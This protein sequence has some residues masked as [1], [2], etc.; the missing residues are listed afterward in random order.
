MRIL[1]VQFLALALAFAAA[2]QGQRRAAPVVADRPQLSEISDSIEGIGTLAPN[3]RVEL[4]VNVADRVTAIYFE[5]GQRV[6]RGQTLLAQAQREQLAAIEGAEAT[7]REAERVVERMTTLVADGVVSGLEFDQAKRNLEVARSE[8]TSV[9]T[10]QRNR[11]LVAP[12]D[13]VLGFRQVSV[14][15]FLSP[16]DPVATLVDDSEMY[17]DVFVPDTALANI[18]PGLDVVA[19]TS[20]LPGEIFNGIL[21]SVDNQI[22]PSTRSLRVRAR[23]PN[24]DQKLR[25]GLFMNVTLMAA[26]RTALSVP[27]AAVEP[28]GSQSFVYIVDRSENEPVARRTEVTLGSRFDGRVEV[29]SGLEISD[30]V[31]VEGLIGVRDGGRVGVKSSA[32]TGGDAETSTA[33]SSTLS[34]IRR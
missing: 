18:A 3:E 4:T 1:I 10:R 21:E 33:D 30:E 20:S 17:V 22:D 26:P 8:L 6:Q 24:V 34:T 13:G 27:E 11:V 9:Q 23:L 2:A 14:G 25:A 19:T 28:L 5:D 32:L 7:A 29:V 16:G 15:A 31:V 12:F